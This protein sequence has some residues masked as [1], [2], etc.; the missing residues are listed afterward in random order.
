MPSRSWVKTVNDINFVSV[1]KI[2]WTFQQSQVFW[3]TLKLT[4]SVYEFPRS[5]HD[6]HQA[7]RVDLAYRVFWSRVVVYGQFARET[8]L[9]QYPSKSFYIHRA[10]CQLC[11]FRRD[12]ISI[13]NFFV[14]LSLGYYT[15][16]GRLNKSKLEPRS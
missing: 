12:L 11:S 15:K 2:C 13:N 9:H 5:H 8:R 14:I 7:S 4:I 16:K 6:W 10:D 1:S 3:K